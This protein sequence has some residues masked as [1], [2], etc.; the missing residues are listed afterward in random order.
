MGDSYLDLY[1]LLRPD[2]HTIGLPLCGPESPVLLWFT[3]QLAEDQGDHSPNLVLST[4]HTAPFSA[5][6]EERTLYLVITLAVT[7][8]ASSDSKIDSQTAV[9]L[10][11]HP[12]TS[13]EK[14]QEI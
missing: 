5:I 10:I 11:L 8:K 9:G 2:Q 14:R 1:K 6:P 12:N 4:A 13:S 7:L 3:L